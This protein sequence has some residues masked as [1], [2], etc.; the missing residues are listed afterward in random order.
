MMC[1]SRIKS[2]LYDFYNSLVKSLQLHYLLRVWYFF[3]FQII[4]GVNTFF[5]LY[6]SDKDVDINMALASFRV[7]AST[8]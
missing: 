7:D 5:E 6:T 1:D 8:R 3:I 2:W 4:P